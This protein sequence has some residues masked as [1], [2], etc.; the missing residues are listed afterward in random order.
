MSTQ[1]DPQLLIFL[2]IPKTAGQTFNRILS[3]QFP[4]RSTV[5][6]GTG[7]ST[8]SLSALASLPETE[9]L[10]VRLVTGHVA[11]GIHELFPQPSR[12]IAFVRDPV[13]R[14]IS[15]YWYVKRTPRHFMHDT[16]VSNDLSLEDYV[17]SGLNP[18]LENGQT[19]LLAGAE[20][21]TATPEL[22]ERAMSNIAERFLLVGL[23]ERFD[24][25]LL[26]LKGALGW[27]DVGYERINATP[28]SAKGSSPSD[29]TLSMIRER[30]RIDDA[31][32]GYCAK[33]FDEHVGAA[34]D[35]FRGEL[36]RFRALNGSPGALLRTRRRLRGAAARS[37]ALASLPGYPWRWAPDSR[38]PTRR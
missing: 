30:N 8:P 1:S 22:L 21:E 35:G 36:E 2:H 6:V 4:R 28:G 32:Y 9:K 14:V 12:Y 26:L 37:S 33:L 18:Q 20:E 3:S 16:I 31:L 15:N 23:T 11:F 13:E 34:G 19:R 29:S 25:T 38:R 7:R 10:Q 24:E 17:T 5:L 27:R